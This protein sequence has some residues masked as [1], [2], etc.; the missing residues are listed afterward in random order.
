MS[1]EEILELINAGFAPELIELEFNVPLEKINKYIKQ[2]EKRK[3]GQKAAKALE[4]KEKG[5]H[6]SGPN[7]DCGRWL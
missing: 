5:D 3:E 2:E 6:G 7:P 1:K 4:Q